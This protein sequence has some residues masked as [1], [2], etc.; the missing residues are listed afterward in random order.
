MSQ[1]TTPLFSVNGKP[2]TIFSHFSLSQT[3]F[4]HHLFTLT[5][6]SEAIDGIAGL[7]TNSR[8][9]IG[10]SFGASI[11]GVGLDGHLQFKGIIT[12]IETSREAGHHQNVVMTG[13]S[14]SV[15]L[16]SGPHCKSWEEKS[17][18][19]IIQD[20]LRFFPQNL[21][22]PQVQPL[23]AARPAY[24]VQY[25]ESAWAF[26]CRLTATYGEWLYWDGSHLVIGP[27]GNKNKI[28]LSYGSSLNSF[29][30]ALQA[31][32]AAMQYL[33]WDYCSNQVNTSQP[34]DVEQKAGANKLG[35]QLLNVSR[36]MYG[37]QPKQTSYV[38]NNKNQL[39]DMVTLRS[40][41]ECSKMIH[42]NGKSGH[43]GL[44]LGTAITVTGANVFGGNAED[45]GEYQ[46]TS[47]E[48]YV[49]NYGNYRNEFTAIPASL[50]V[51]PVDIPSEPGCETQSGVVT[52]NND[53]KGMGRVRVKLH[54]MNESEKTPWIRVAAAHAGGEKGTFFIPEKGEE[55]II[56]F[57]GD[58][59]AR[60]YVIG[61]VYNGRD[62]NSFSN[63]GNDIK[64]I[65]TRSGHV[66]EFS[67][68]GNGTHII[69]R[70]PGGNEIRMDTRGKNITITSPETM[71][72]NA[73]NMKLNVTDNMDVSVGKNKTETVGH[74]ATHIVNNK[75]YLR[76]NEVHNEITE[77]MKTV[78][79]EKIEEYTQIREMHVN[80]TT[81]IIS[82]GLITIKSG[83]G[84][85]YGE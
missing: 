23:S 43:P 71:T 35:G 54:W 1:L 76:S 77:K 28:N 57:E 25:K 46:I 36:K 73:K 49:D 38:Y 10:T 60:P 72:L 52:D 9:M 26:L 81:D 47:I 75:T 74:D 33:S 39:D 22:D 41:I 48:H 18:S 70:D 58:N 14:I 30:L 24:F 13:Y 27:P 44:S 84:V 31:R 69:I 15:I 51:P 42:F 80:G 34:K 62:S 32:P 40:A 82:T 67:D 56:G 64:T 20:V 45:Y 6:P 83:K 50:K 78:V 37:T 55:V 17:L 3:I 53:P 19:D 12:G 29:N 79:M 85:D 65:K 8:D 66:I 21:L 2:L 7:F 68:A 4:D 63:E 16:D 59:A 61:S 5:C 11:A